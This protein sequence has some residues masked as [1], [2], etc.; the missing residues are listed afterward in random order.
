MVSNSEKISA[1]IMGFPKVCKAIAIIYVICFCISLFAQTNNRKEQ[2][3]NIIEQ[4]YKPGL[5]DLD[6]GKSQVLSFVNK[7]EPVDVPLIYDLVFDKTIPYDT[8][9]KLARTAAFLHPNKEQINRI[10]S[11]TVD[12]LPQPKTGI[13]PEDDIIDPLKQSIILLY[14][15]T[16]DDGLLQPFRTLYEDNACWNSCRIQILSLL[17]KTPSSSN[18]SLYEKILTLAGSAEWERRSAIFGIARESSMKSLPYLREMAN[19]LFDPDDKDASAYS[20]AVE[21]LGRLS[22]KDYAASVEIQDTITKVCNTNEYG[23]LMKKNPEFVWELFNSLRMSDDE[24]NRKYLEN[25]LQKDCNYK[26]GKQ[27]AIKALA[28]G[29]VRKG[30]SGF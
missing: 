1:G 4:Y 20:T 28:L 2:I 17:E 25:L 12:N 18:I 8:R 13:K 3:L 24:R 7:L 23:S 6:M 26:N 19:Y 21:L 9:E 29:T 15:N 5:F 11:F 10:M 22:E 14:G 16:K 30:P 27:F